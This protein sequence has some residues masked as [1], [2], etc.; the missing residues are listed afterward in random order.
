[1]PEYHHSPQPRSYTVFRA[2]VGSLVLATGGAVGWLLWA[3]ILPMA[4][5]DLPAILSAMF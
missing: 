3:W 4:G 5:I 1:M 2:V